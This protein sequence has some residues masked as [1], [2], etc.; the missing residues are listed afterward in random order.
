MCRVR[1][2]ASERTRHTKNLKNATVEIP[3]RYRIANLQK[4][5]T[6]GSQSIFELST[7]GLISVINHLA[8][9]PCIQT[10]LDTTIVLLQV[11]AGVA[12]NTAATERTRYT[13]PPG[14]CSR[15]C[16]DIG[17]KESGCVLPL[18]VWEMLIFLLSG[19][20]RGVWFAI[21]CPAEEAAMQWKELKPPKHCSHA[22]QCTVVK[23]SVPVQ[24]ISGTSS[25]V[26]ILC[27]VLSGCKEH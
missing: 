12:L 1:T 23:C 8:Q 17:L 6:P 19:H 21:K 2:A 3:P 7:F 5:R 24:A 22:A 13:A 14:V 4:W 9:Q 16:Q 27:Q 25:S 11:Q 20:Y 10:V 26:C 15:A 18:G